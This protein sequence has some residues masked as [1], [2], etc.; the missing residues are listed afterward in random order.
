MRTRCNVDT[1][2]IRCWYKCAKACKYYIPMSDKMTILWVI[3]DSFKMWLIGISVSQAYCWPWHG[4]VA[5]MTNRKLGFKRIHSD[6]KFNA[7]TALMIP[8]EIRP[9]NYWRNL[10]SVAPAP[11][12]NLIS[13]ALRYYTTQY[14]PKTFR[15]ELCSLSKPSHM[16]LGYIYIVTCWRQRA[17]VKGFSHANHLY[18]PSLLY[19]RIR[20]V[21]GIRHYPEIP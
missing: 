6:R 1:M 16:D 21:T 9:I 7:D 17:T 3:N 14:P 19:L 4:C 20:D 12:I 18:G 10:S 13:W 11:F 15:I 8:L 5:S 2:L